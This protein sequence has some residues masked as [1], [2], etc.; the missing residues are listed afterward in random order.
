MAGMPPRIMK[1]KGDWFSDTSSL[2]GRD[3]HSSARGCENNRCK[4]LY[5]PTSALIRVKESCEST[6]SHS[7]ALMRNQVRSDPSPSKARD[8]LAVSR[9]MPESRRKA[10][11]A[12]GDKAARLASTLRSGL[13]LLTGF[14]ASRSG[15]GFFSRVA[16]VMIDVLESRTRYCQLAVPATLL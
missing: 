6:P 10:S 2:F 4:P 15:S 13:D 11:T 14:W 5:R 16:V 12:A 7:R 3:T 8:C 9:Q 1:F